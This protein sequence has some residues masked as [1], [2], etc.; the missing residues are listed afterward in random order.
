MGR[1]GCGGAG[2]MWWGGRDVVVGGRGG[3][4]STRPS[5][6]KS[7]HHS[8]CWMRCTGMTMSSTNRSATSRVSGSPV[9]AARWGGGGGSR[10]RVRP[11]E[12]R[13]EQGAWGRAL[14]G[15]TAWKHC[16]ETLH[17]G[18]AR[19]L[20]S[21]EGAREQHKLCLPVPGPGRG[22]GGYAWVSGHVVGRGR[23]VWMC[24][25]V[26]RGILRENVDGARM[27]AS[28]HALA[29]QCTGVVRVEG[30]EGGG[31]GARKLCTHP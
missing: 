9:K 22:R 19:G 10:M 2:G 1:E 20:N 8:F 24:P 12:P 18:E 29:R 4:L 26:L 7:M 31:G 3:K 15:N 16:M 28:K 21:M 6:E 30:D 17:G 27:Q 23:S 13:Q 14:H 5:P 11:C 25:W